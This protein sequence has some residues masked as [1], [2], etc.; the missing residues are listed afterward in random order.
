MMKAET[1]NYRTLKPERDGLF[2]ER[3]FGPTKSWTCACG[4]IKRMRFKGKVCDKCGVLIAPSHVRRT[5]MGHIELAVPIAHIWY[6]Q[7]MPSRIGLLLDITPGDL[8]RVLYYSHHIIT[9]VDEQARMRE[10]ARIQDEIEQLEQGSERLVPV[11][12][13]Q[14]PRVDPAFVAAASLA[15]A[16][17]RIAQDDGPKA[18]QDQGT[19]GQDFRVFGVRVWRAEPEEV[20]QVEDDGED[21]DTEYPAVGAGLAPA[22][23]AELAP[24]L[25]PQALLPEEDNDG[26][27]GDEAGQGPHTLALSLR[28]ILVEEDVDDLVEIEV[29]G[30]MPGERTYIGRGSDKEI[31]VGQ[32]SH[33][34]ASSL[35]EQLEG[36]EDPALAYLTEHPEEVEE[37]EIEFEAMSAHERCEQLR[38]VLALLSEILPLRL[39]NV[40]EYRLLQAECA[41]AFTAGIGA[42]AIREL[43]ARIDLDDLAQSLRMSMPE[44][45]GTARSRIIK[46]LKIVQAFQHSQT[47][48][49]WMI[50]TV[51]PVLPPDMRPVLVMD[52]GRFTAADVNELY[53]RVIHRNNRLKRFMELDAPDIIL[54][55]EKAAVQNACDALFNNAHT[56]RPMVGPSKRPLKSLTDAITGKGG[57]FRHNLL[58]KRVDY[59]G[60]SVISVG[61]DLKVHQCGL[62]KKIVLELFKPFIIRKLLEYGFFESPKQAKR[63]V[64]R[65]DPVVWDVIDEAMEG[66]VVL[67][68]RA[69]SLHRLSIQAFEPVIVEGSAIRLHPQVCSPF[70]ADFDGDQMAVH[71]P[72][73]DEAQKEA[74]ELMLSTR[75]LLSPAS[76]EPT[77]SISQ[78]QVLGCYYL[79]QER[80]GKQGEGRTFSDPAQAL[81]AYDHDIVGLQAPIWVRLPDDYLY[82]QLLPAAGRELSKDEKIKT[83]V[84]RLLFNEA[85]PKYMRF[86]NYAMKK[87]HLKQLV[88][89]CIKLYGSER[90]AVMTD[91]IKRLGFTH[92]TRAGISFA[93]SD[94]SVPRQKQ[95]ILNEADAKV[96]ELEEVWRS[97]LITREELRQQTIE[98]WQ[99]ATDE[100]ASHVQSTLDPYGSITTIS[101][102]GATKAKLQQIRQLSGM[103]GLMASP[104]GGI[105]ETP[106][107]GNFLEGLSM[108][109]YFLSS[110][111]ARKSLMDRSLNTAESGYLTIRFVNVAQEVIVKEADCGTEDGIIIR[112]IESKEIGFADNRGRLIGRVLAQD[113]PLLGLASGDEIDDPTADMLVAGRITEVRVR[114]VLRCQTRNGGVC[115]RCYGW[116]L[117]KRAM[118]Q[119]GTAV[120]I[121]AAQSI[122]EPGTQLTMRTFHSGGIAGGQGDI[123]QGIPRVEELFEARS[124]KDP[125]LISEVAGRVVIEKNAETGGHIIHVDTIDEEL[126]MY[127]L[128]PGGILLV[129]EHSRVSVGQLIALQPTA[130]TTELYARSAGEIVLRDGVP[131]IRM[132][133]TSRCSYHLPPGRKPTVE[134]GQTIQ[135]GT[136]LTAGAR[137]LQEL[138]QYQGTEAL[139]FYILKEAQRVYRTTGAYIH[140]KHFEIIIRQMVRR[141]QID[142]PGDTT[143]L[144]EDLIDN[145]TLADMNASVEEIGGTPATA[146]GVLLGLTR[147]TLATDS[148][149][150]AASFQ[151]TSRILTE[152]VL[153]GKTDHL[154]GIK[155]NVILGKLIPAGTGLLPR[156]E[157]PKVKRPVQHG[158]RGRP[159][160][161][162]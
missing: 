153:E 64:E 122:G 73:T 142:D 118:V 92:A 15:N 72:L 161:L 6:A 127:P 45:E 80:P 53:C 40:D 121:I 126:D 112:E 158:Q 17:Q 55:R 35:Q 120:G 108:A 11:R 85:L 42:E 50:F 9:H 113:V 115:Q 61:L 119:I 98:L 58:G 145:L 16:E 59:S 131:A 26:D 152:A 36:V 139:E 30:K 48:P 128:G 89:E 8:D 159:R 130:R 7:G 100:I 41:E 138:Q 81:M 137:I 20:L 33:T 93:I 136:S 43:L 116:D 148:W 134:T 23:W 105:V 44:H 90:T 75:N 47:R 111:G 69:P 57:R 155:E 157:R 62:P 1:L 123:T 162:P 91:E 87:D 22:L 109:E 99:K 38:T 76:G 5:R 160:K 54:N 39:L 32:G 29:L 132:E 150:A 147:A 125:A 78:E 95:G 135:A 146:H 79:T 46:R 14:V 107:R 77:I 67:L 27:E 10:I 104:S 70:N 19:A 25:S 63:A 31:E 49:E 117:S 37:W 97:G 102:S 86:H 110:H 28:E 18:A 114:S 56:S 66:K 133:L 68:N 103:R 143:L 71:L 82:D 151:Q 52:G 83:T 74:R 156:A 154:L 12:S 84:G 144:P 106:V 34:L 65:K 124:P 149:L 94:V 88:W 21:E 101:N 141:V 13:Q 96:V 129:A 51:I 140:D 60:R 4:K 2:C 3:I 24:A